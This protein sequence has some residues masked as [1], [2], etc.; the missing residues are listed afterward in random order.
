MSTLQ[1][2]PRTRL[3]DDD[4]EFASD[5][6]YLNDLLDAIVHECHTHNRKVRIP[7]LSFEFTEHELAQQESAGKRSWWRRIIPLAWLWLFSAIVGCV[8]VLLSTRGVR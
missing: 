8:V 2:D 5:L 4:M 1:G 6:A 3:T 7:E